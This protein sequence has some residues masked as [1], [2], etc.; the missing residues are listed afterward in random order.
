MSRLLKIAVLLIALL[1]LSLK[2]QS[3]YDVFMPIGKYL[4]QGDAEKLSSWFADN[5]EITLV[6]RT[7]VTS[8]NQARQMIKT[9]FDD[10]SPRSFDINHT[11]SD[12][13]TKYAVGS[14]NAGGE[15]YMV[16]IF[17]SLD[18]D[19]YVIQQIKIDP[20]R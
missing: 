1:P 12:N 3:G 8:R 17:V 11:A 5:L 14:L 2:A 18:S 6:S 13:G 19:R 10:H 16:T 7:A 20:M 4:S 9:F 15:M